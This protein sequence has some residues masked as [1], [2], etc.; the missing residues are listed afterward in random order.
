VPSQFSLLTGDD[1]IQ[2]RRSDFD[3]TNTVR[4][5]SPQNV[6]AAVREIFA[7]C[8]PLASFDSVWLAFHDFERYFSGRDPD[9]HGVDTTYHDMQHTL[10][11]TLAM[12]RLIAGYESSVE[13][14]DRLGAERAKFGVVSALFHDF[15]YLR[16][17]ERDREN[18]NGAEFTL[19]HVTRSG[20]FIEK[21]LPKIG[22]DAF[23]PVATRVVHFTGYEMSP[24]QIELNDPRDSVTGHLLGTAD[25]LA[26]LADRCYL[27]KCRDRL[28]P[29]FVLGNVAVSDGPE[30]ARAN[31]WSGQDLLFKT[32]DF[33]QKSAQYRLEHS[34]N[35]AYRYVEA[36][37]ERGENPY[38]AFIR[39]NLTFLM[40]VKERGSWELL[41]RRPPCVIPDPNGEARL[42]ALALKKLREISETERATSMRLRALRPSLSF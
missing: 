42:V 20:A 1:A 6:C 32:M 3:V 37:F 40:Q 17:R 18:A 21:Y 15:G 36:I 27:E 19:T 35:R 25:L 4:V 34:F 28:Y 39:K 10:D 24:D 31:F 16:H 7:G 38:I 9:Y 33:Y 12:A 13:P 23:A 8:Y 14:S 41:R 5:S 11:M 22:L 30:G 29:E 2:E 26:Q